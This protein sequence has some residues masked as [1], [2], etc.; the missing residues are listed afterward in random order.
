ME[1]LPILLFMPTSKYTEFKNVNFDQMIVEFDEFTA[2]EN[3]GKRCQKTGDYKK[4]SINNSSNF[5]EQVKT[6]H[7]ILSFRSV[8]IL[9]DF[10]RIT[11]RYTN[12]SNLKDKFQTLD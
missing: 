12:S 5:Q 8:A 2:C 1:T 9:D 4:I 10:F 11:P 7:V 3:G 6:C